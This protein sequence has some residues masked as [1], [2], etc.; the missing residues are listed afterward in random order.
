MGWIAATICE[1]HCN[2]STLERYFL[3]T[4]FFNN[5]NEEKRGYIDI[6]WKYVSQQTTLIRTGIL[7][8]HI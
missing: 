1:I 8:M 3:R 5:V 6:C 7:N 2:S 4:W